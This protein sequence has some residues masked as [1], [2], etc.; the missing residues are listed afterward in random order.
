MGGFDPVA[1]AHFRWADPDHFAAADRMQD[2]GSLGGELERI[3][4][5]AR[6]DRV[7]ALPLFPCHG[8]SQEVVRLVACPLRVHEPAGCDEGRQQLELV[9]QLAVEDASGLVGRKRFAAIGRRIKR[10]P[11]HQDSPGSLLLVEAQERVGEANDRTA[12]LVAGPPDRFR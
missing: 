10:V 6:D 12:T 11:A 1:L 2:R 3:P 9:Q 7:A 5:P 4:V 8:R